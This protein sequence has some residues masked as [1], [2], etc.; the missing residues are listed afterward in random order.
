MGEFY[1]ISVFHVVFAAKNEKFVVNDYRQ[2][3]RNFSGFCIENLN[4]FSE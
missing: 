1:V 3:I 4:I 2:L